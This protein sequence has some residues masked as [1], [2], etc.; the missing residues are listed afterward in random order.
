M[1]MSILVTLLHYPNIIVIY[2]DDVFE[3][4]SWITLKKLKHRGQK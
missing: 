2:I 3:W 1:S 4:L